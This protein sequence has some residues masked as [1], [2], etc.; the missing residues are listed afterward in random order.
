MPECG[1]AVLVVSVVRFISPIHPGSLLLYIFSTRRGAVPC[2]GAIYTHTLASYPIRH[3][4]DGW[5]RYAR[6]D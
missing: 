5:A 6:K 3:E 1:G 2:C 4:G